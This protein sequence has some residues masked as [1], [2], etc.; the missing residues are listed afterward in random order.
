[1]LP[2]TSPVDTEST[3][4]IAS[5]HL[6]IIGGGI[7]GLA[8]AYYAM[9]AAN[10]SGHP[11]RCTVLEGSNRLGGKIATD[12]VGVD[13]SFVLERGADSFL[14]QKPYA[15][16]LARELGLDGKLI[17]INAAPHPT[18]VLV[19]G[20]LRVF[21]PGMALI[22][23]TDW[24]TFARSDVL[25][26]WGRA[27]VA[28][29][30]LM[31]RRSNA[32]D[33][34]LGSFVRRRLGEE[35]VD[36]LAEPL[37][38]GIY[39]S[40]IMDMSLQATFPRYADLELQYGSVIRGVR[41]SRRQVSDQNSGQRLP[42]FY[43]FYE[44]M[45]TLIS[46]L[47]DK[48]GNMVRTKAMVTAIDN[49]IGEPHPYYLRLSNGDTL[50]ADAVVMAIPAEVTAK[51]LAPLQPRM[52]TIL[53]QFQALSTGTVSLAYRRDEIGE[54][55]DGYGVILPRSE[56]RPINAI[57]I[58]SAKFNHRAPDD[59]VLVRVF[60]GGSRNPIAMSLDD[61]AL[62]EVVQRELRSILGINVAPR[63]SRIYRLYHSSPQYTVGHLDRV[64]ELEQL[65]LPGLFLTGS[66]YRGVGIPDCV[67]QGRL[68]GEAAFAYLQE[69]YRK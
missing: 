17:P 19:D 55:M 29:E 44:G 59:S 62:L 68:A 1:M 61:V 13:Q 18:Y 50:T 24:N 11:I 41:Q 35:A 56:R 21:P 34:S 37:L 27:R 40:D 52:S 12:F 63:F 48:L 43:T 20:K 7:S 51:L 32:G 9:R 16:E 28:L 23:P 60:F 5:S 69:Q 15:T 53:E 10:A 26:P 33:E 14:T 30:T 49:I 46:A 45:E 22:I 2:F 66:P 25:S 67:R 4:P 58:S 65:C 57:T 31:P 3:G 42:A 47:A 64:A 38:A 6:V 8:T 54:L 39:N 36:R